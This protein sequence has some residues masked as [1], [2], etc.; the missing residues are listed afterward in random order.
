MRK[1]YLYDTLLLH[2]THLG[3][4]L[5]ILDHFYHTLFIASGDA[6]IRDDVEVQPLGLPQL[7]TSRTRMIQCM[8]KSCSGKYVPTC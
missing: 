2:T 7:N 3:D 5:C 1:G 6:A 8:N 4:R